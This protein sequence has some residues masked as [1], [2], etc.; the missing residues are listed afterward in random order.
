MMKR[1]IKLIICM[2]AVIV[3]FL[4]SSQVVFASIASHA[5]DTRAVFG[6]E[7]VHESKHLDGSNY[8]AIGYRVDGKNIYRIYYENEGQRDWDNTIVCLDKDGRF[9]ATQDAGGRVNKGRYKSLGEATQATLSS[10]KRSIDAEGAKRINWLINNAL[11]PE[12]SDDLQKQKIAE[13]FDAI[14]S[15]TASDVNPVR[16]ED[17]RSVLTKDDLVIA[18]QLA[19]WQVTNGATPRKHSRYI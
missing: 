18:L 16:V 15:S 5:K 9:P 8:A 19:V 14:I 17:I 3:L 1:S 11:L 2:I 12:D 7:Q 13:A 4:E 10:V 6:I